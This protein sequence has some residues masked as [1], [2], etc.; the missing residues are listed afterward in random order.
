MKITRGGLLFAWLMAAVG[1]VFS[2][3]GVL[4]VAA[5][6]DGAWGWFLLGAG[7]VLL[8]LGVSSLVIRIRRRMHARFD[9]GH[10]DIPT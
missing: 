3:L 8:I 9:R 5:D 4:A 1:A 7:P 6:R 2:L 10:P